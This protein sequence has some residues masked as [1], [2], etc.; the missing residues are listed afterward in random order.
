VRQ[1][2]HHDPIIRR[3][4]RPQDVLDI[5]FKG[6]TIHTAL[7]DKGR[8]PPPK[9]RRLVDVVW[10]RKSGVASTTARRRPP[11][12]QAGQTEV[13]AIS[14]KMQLAASGTVPHALSKSGRS[15]TRP[16][17]V[18]YRGATFFEATVT[19]SSRDTMLPLVE[20]E[21]DFDAPAQLIGEISGWA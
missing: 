1:I 9:L 6:R 14:S 12:T 13:G 19:V 3:Q 20:L 21:F 8:V 2:V 16:F 17:P 18:R 4:V 11:A 15:L 7:E 5:G 10:S